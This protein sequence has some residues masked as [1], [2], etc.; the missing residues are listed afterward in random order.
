MP[1]GLPG[2]TVRVQIEEARARFARGQIVEILQPSPDRIT[3]RCKHFGVCGGCHFQHLPYEAQLRAKREI[4]ADQLTRLGGFAH[5]PVPETLPS[6]SPWA[7]R[8]H[9]QFSLTPQ[10]R[11]GYKRAGSDETFAIDECHILDPRIGEVWP[12]LE[13]E[14]D[15]ARDIERLSLRAGAS[16]ELMMLLESET[17]EAPDIT[18][19]L[20]LSI[21][22]LRPDGP[23]SVLAGADAFVEEVNGRSFRVSAGSFFQ[24]NTPLAGDMVRRVMDHLDLQGHETVLDLYCGVGL[25]SAFIAEKAARVI[26][27]EASPSAAADFEVNLDE[28]D[29]VELYE[30]PVEDALPALDLRP[31]AVVLDPPRAG[32][33]PNALA[34][35]I[36]LAP[37]K[38][39]YV[40]CHP[41]TLARDGKALA[42]AGYTLVEALPVDMFPQTYH[43]ES[44]SR[45]EAGGMGQTSDVKVQPASRGGPKD[46][47]PE[48]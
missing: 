21:V 27:I 30:A 34:A 40:S 26:G 28:F 39:V 23:A 25:F 10:G 8:N 2:E 44:I 41:S 43:L 38:I 14:P 47:A 29:N 11:L 31:D 35:L 6:P 32:L 9:V 5:P 12:R 45:W 4:L 42:G 15:A 46:R 33:D 1:F 24:V 7:Y 3:P 48:A 16:D 36:Q 37:P 20:P 17:G 19:E 13:L 22:A 18:S